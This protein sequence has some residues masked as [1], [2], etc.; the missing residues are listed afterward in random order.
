[1]NKMKAIVKANVG[2]PSKVQSLQRIREV[3]AMLLLAKPRSEI[4]DF[5][6]STYGVQES[7]VNNIISQA[8]KYLAETHKID[9]DG[10]IVLHLQYYYDI[11]VLAKSMADSRGAIAALNSIEK[12][13][14]LTPP[15]TAIQ[16]NSFN[17]DVSK[18]DFNQLKELLEVK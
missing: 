12:L 14:K 17:I 13:L 16:N 2:R 18:L 6:C 15:E 1:M 9:R 7:S 3:A 10:T 4:I 11:Y 8:Y 5:V